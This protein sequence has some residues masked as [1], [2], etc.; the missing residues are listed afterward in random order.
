M[1]QRQIS[2]VHQDKIERDADVPSGQQL[3]R[4]SPVAR[5]ERKDDEP[6]TAAINSRACSLAM[7]IGKGRSGVSDG[8][9]LFWAM[10]PLL[11]IAG[12]PAKPVSDEIGDGHRFSERPCA[13]KKAVPRQLPVGM[14]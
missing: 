4:Q 13:G 2:D 6:T 7:R 11:A 10:A 5:Q 8:E 9:G 14:G 12:D 1:S 3:R